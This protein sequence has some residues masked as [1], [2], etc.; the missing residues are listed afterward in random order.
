MTDRRQHYWLFA[1]AMPMASACAQ[2][3]AVESSAAFADTAATTDATDLSLRIAERMKFVASRHQLAAPSPQVA[4][5]A[6]VTGPQLVDA[7][8]IPATLRPTLVSATIPDPDAVVVRGS[9]GRIQPKKG[10]S[11]LLMSTAKE[12]VFS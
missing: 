3:E 5:A 1:L 4:L 12:G 9:Y 2:P 7:L 10:T 11:F 8:D 6:P